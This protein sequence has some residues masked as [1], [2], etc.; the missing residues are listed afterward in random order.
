MEA[1]DK[2]KKK[3]PK[4]LFTTED[5]DDLQFVWMSLEDDEGG[6]ETDSEDDE[7]ISFLDLT[8]EQSSNQDAQIF[9]ANISFVHGKTFSTHLKRDTG[10]VVNVLSDRQ[11]SFRGIVLDTGANRR[12]VMCLNQYRQYCKL[13]HLPMK[14]DHSD[15]GGL[16][17]LGGRVRAIGSA[18]IS[19]PF[20]DLE[21]MI[22]VRFR[23]MNRDGPTLLSLR[24]MYKKQLDISIQRKVITHN[25]KSMQLSFESV[26]LYTLRKISRG[27]TASLDIRRSQH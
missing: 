4:I 1:L 9:L 13:F 20:K 3:N 24:D 11:H 18:T 10:D 14:I 16:I 17:G 5:V 15:Q 26:L 19:I 22:Y 7:Q 25:E 27:C 6:S 21:L 2:S 8:D 23:I 12:S